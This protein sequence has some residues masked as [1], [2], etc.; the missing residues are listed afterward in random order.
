MSPIRRC[1]DEE[2]YLIKRDLLAGQYRLSLLSRATLSN[3]D[4]VDLCSARDTRVLKSFLACWR[5]ICRS[6]AAAATSRVMEVRNML[7]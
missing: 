2:K 1:W 5:G 3:D 6:R 7:S 4:E